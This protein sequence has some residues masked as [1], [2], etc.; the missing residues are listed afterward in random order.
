MVSK[1]ELSF[2]ALL[3]RKFLSAYMEQRKHQFANIAKLIIP[4]LNKQKFYH[5]EFSK[6][7]LKS[8]SYSKC[9]RYKHCIYPC[10]LDI[11]FEV[12]D[13]DIMLISI[14]RKVYRLAFVHIN[15]VD[16]RIVEYM[17]VKS[18]KPIVIEIYVHEGTCNI[19]I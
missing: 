15:D 18:S 5:Y 9:E 19:P 13:Y 8:S 6:E 12:N 2:I 16:S 7:G 11:C 17:L 10:P 3:H 14:P 1:L 4:S